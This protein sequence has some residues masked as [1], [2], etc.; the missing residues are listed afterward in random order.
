MVSEQGFDRDDASEVDV[1]NAFRHWYELYQAVS[2]LAG[3]LGQPEESVCR[4]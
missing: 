4:N 2:I 3:K 1:L